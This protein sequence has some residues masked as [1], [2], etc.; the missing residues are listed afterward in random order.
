MAWLSA[1]AIFDPDRLGLAVVGIA[2][3][4]RDHDSGEHQHEMGQLLFAQ[5][6]CISIAF[7][8]RLC[9]LPPARVA[10][11]PPRTIH[12]A[13]MKE[14]V[15]YR[16]VYLG[17]A[18]VALLPTSIQVLETTPLLCAVLERMATASFNTD[19]RRGPA[20]HLL[21]V[22]L[23][24]I[25]RAPRTPTMLK[26]PLD[27]RLACLP[28]NELPPSLKVLAADVGASEKTIS[29]IFKRE[30]GLTYQ[31]WRQQWRFLKSIELLAQQGCLSSI[32]KEL[33]FASDSAFVAFFKSMTDLT[34][35]AYMA[36][37]AMRAK[38]MS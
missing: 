33:G 7:Q 3:Q 38:T 16:S 25:H 31:Q 17:E 1:D 24:E 19:W 2:A 26:L 37:S 12:R 5:G 6:G 22:C 9:I 14:A 30:T 35:R 29:R 11:I 32:A 28:N 15:G 20:A 18:Q 34:P 4:L 8:N 36:A 23:D 10:W 27:H 21:G 13:E